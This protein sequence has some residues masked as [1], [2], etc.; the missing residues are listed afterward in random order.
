MG[1]LIEINCYKLPEREKEETFQNQKINKENNN[2]N[3][4]NNEHSNNNNENNNIN[5][6]DNNI[7]N[8]NI[9]DDDKSNNESYRYYRVQD[10]N[11]MNP[12]GSTPQYVVD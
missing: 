9:I 8:S 5:N 3:I 4:N 11:C 7:N 1:G 2:K 10:I 12:K 6:I